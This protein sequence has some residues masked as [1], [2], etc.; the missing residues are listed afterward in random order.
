MVAIWR[1]ICQT[2][3]SERKLDTT[4]QLACKYNFGNAPYSKIGA[5]RI[6]RF[7]KANKRLEETKEPSSKLNEK[8]KIPSNVGTLQ[9]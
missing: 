7:C 2:S 1:H 6:G 3:L 8:T 4:H 5:H 9:Q